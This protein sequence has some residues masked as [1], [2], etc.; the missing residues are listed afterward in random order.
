[1]LRPSRLPT[2]LLLVSMLGLTAVGIWLL[3]HPL[4]VGWGMAVGGGL[5]SLVSA[6]QLLPNSAYVRLTTE[7][8]TVRHLFRMRRVSWSDVEWCFPTKR[9]VQI[10]YVAHRGGR[11][12]ATLPDT[13]GMPP[14]ELAALLNRWRVR[15][16]SEKLSRAG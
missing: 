4:P 13:Y 1:M 12:M 8:L 14:R 6:I 2:V 5:A 7:G 3:Q 9:G 10:R 11:T 16:A 15:A